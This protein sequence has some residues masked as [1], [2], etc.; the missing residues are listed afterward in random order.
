[1]T[2]NLIKKKKNEKLLKKKNRMEKVSSDDNKPIYRK[3]KKVKFNDLECELKEKL[4]N[5][6]EEKIRI[7][8]KG[9]KKKKKKKKIH[10]TSNNNNGNISGSNN[11]YYNGNNNYD[12]NNN[13]VVDTSSV[14]VTDYT[15]MLPPRKKIKNMKKEDNNESEMKNEDNFYYTLDEE[16]TKHEK[17][18]SNDLIQ[19]SK[20]L[21][22]GEDNLTENKKNVKYK[23]SCNSEEDILKKKEKK[24]SLKEKKKKKEKNFI[25]QG[26]KNEEHNEEEVSTMCNLKKTTKNNKKDKTKVHNFLKENHSKTRKNNFKNDIKKLSIYNKNKENIKMT[27]EVTNRFTVLG[28]DWDNISS[29]DVFYLFESYYNFE[30]RKKKFIDYSKSRAVKKVTIY[31]SK[32]GEKKLKYEQEHGPLIN[33]DLLRRKGENEGA[34]YR[35]NNFL[36][37]IK[38]DESVQ[39]GH[40]EGND[41]GEGSKGSNQDENNGENQSDDK[42]LK[43]KKKK[44]A[45]KKSSNIA[46]IKKERNNNCVIWNRHVDEEEE[47]ENEKIRLY[48]IQR[49]R[50]YFALVECY[51]KEIVEFLYEELNDMDADFCINYLDLRIIDDNCSLDDYKIKETCDRIPE[52]Y[53]FRYSIS[54]ALK[55]TYAKSTWDENPKRKKLLSTKFTEENLRELDLKEYLANSSSDDE[56]DHDKNITPVNKNEMCNKEHYRKLLLGDIINEN[57]TP[58]E[59]EINIDYFPSDNSSEHSSNSDEGERKEKSADDGNKEKECSGY[60]NN[61]EKETIKKISVAHLIKKEKFEKI[62]TNNKKAQV[63]NTNQNNL[64]MKSNNKNNN[65]KNKYKT[66]GQHIITDD[67]NSDKDN[68]VVQVF[69]NILI[70]KEKKEDK[71]TP[72]ETYLDRVRHKR[73]IKK[74]AYIDSMKKKDEEIKKIITKK[75]NKRKKDAIIKNQGENVN[76]KINENHQIDSR[77]ADL[78]KNKDFNLDITN[79][80]YKKTKFNEDI[81]QKKL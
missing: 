39:S 71:K 44:K 62:S 48:Q 65:E 16:Y 68:E 60:F 1:M 11:D 13:V 29:V 69:K 64:T 49:S 36:D 75:T 45:K 72:W 21:K 5:I 33:F 63:S 15:T 59:K 25:I 47:E 24:S 41:K 53:Q 2:D 3:K 74:K 78:Y 18:K 52:N 42:N 70:N 57:T 20:Q 79:P 34:L 46:K 26:K 6:K 37:Y 55:H 40:S 8:D 31:T 19:I 61:N 66:K 43:K 81:L 22:N 23:N 10:S 28:C 9:E 77:F 76:E 12:K 27:F 58:N 7:N 14:A 35:R 73:K 32:Y 17:K 38:D 80:N 50:Y 51:S 30:K 56:D 4:N 67:D 54:T